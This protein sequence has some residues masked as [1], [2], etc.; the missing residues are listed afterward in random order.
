[1][2]PPETAH[3]ENRTEDERTRMTRS[4]ILAI[5]EDDMANPSRLISRPPG[6]HDTL[7][8]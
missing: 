6:W 2:N 7:L 3:T 5:I 8:D 4:D 1:M